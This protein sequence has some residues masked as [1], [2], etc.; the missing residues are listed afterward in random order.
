MEPVFEE[1][2]RRKSVAYVHPNPS[3]DA[4]AH[5]LGLP[6]NL[7]DFP[8][9]TN[10]AVAQMHYM[11]RFAPTPNVKYIFSHAGDSIPY[12]AARFAIIEEMGF[13]PGGEQR[14]AAADGAQ[15]AELGT[16]GRQRGT[17]L[18]AGAVGN[19]GRSVVFTAKESGWTVMQAYGTSKRKRRKRVY[20]LHRMGV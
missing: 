5:L 3:P 18:V 1:L 6:D 7:L 16:R 4:I 9:D 2:A 14:G 17:V 12:L 11:N 20:W 10:R 19:V 13:I 8:T 15:L